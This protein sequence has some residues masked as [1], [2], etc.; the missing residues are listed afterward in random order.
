MIWA[1]LL[2]LLFSDSLNTSATD[3]SAPT[4]LRTIRI[5]HN[6][7]E[8]IFRGRP[9]DLTC[10][11]DFPKDSV[12]AVTLFIKS[13]TMAAY[14]EVPLK[15]K[16]SLYS[17][18]AYDTDFPGDTLTYFFT[19]ELEDKIFAIPLDNTG[20]VRPVVREYIDARDYYHL[21]QK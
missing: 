7:P 16:L 8:I 9:Y 2:S 5:I 12:Q 11:V 13:N 10:F 20:R 19:V 1:V 18:R 14:R 4:F 6:P 17:F 3:L 21:R 15:G